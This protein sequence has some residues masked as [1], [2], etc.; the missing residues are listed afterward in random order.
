MMI[1]SFFISIKKKKKKKKRKL[2]L[3]VP[4]KTKLCIAQFIERQ[5]NLNS[6]FSEKL[7]N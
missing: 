5:Y 6:V 1:V 7:F 4:N 2:E 3:V